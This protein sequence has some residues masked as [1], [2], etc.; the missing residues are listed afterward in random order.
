LALIDRGSEDISDSLERGD[1]RVDL[2]Q[3]F[4]DHLEQRQLVLW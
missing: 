2:G 4:G 3:T 1:L